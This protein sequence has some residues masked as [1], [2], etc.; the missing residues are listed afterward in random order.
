[1]SFNC[2]VCG[3]EYMAE[4][5]SSACES[6]PAEEL[7]FDIGTVY[8]KDDLIGMLY[9]SEIVAQTH[10]RKYVVV[11]ATERSV[12]SRRGATREYFEGVLPVTD[13]EFDLF[14]SKVRES[15]QDWSVADGHGVPNIR[16]IEPVPYR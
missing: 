1:M 4:R 7:P 13:R 16:Y 6:L 2:N 3:A 9:D 5:L 14:N 15:Y 10:E 11:E 12:G 8:K